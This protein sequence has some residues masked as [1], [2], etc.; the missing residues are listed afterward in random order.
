MRKRITQTESHFTILLV[1]T[2]ILLTHANT[3]THRHQPT[4]ISGK[5]SPV[6]SPTYGRQLQASLTVHRMRLDIDDSDADRWLT[7]GNALFYARYLI[8][9]RNMLKVKNYVE[10]HFR[11]YFFDE[12]EYPA[13]NCSSMLNDFPS[14]VSRSD[15]K[16]TM[17]IENNMDVD[18]TAIAYSCL[19]WQING[20]PLVGLFKLNLQ[21]VSYTPTSDF[22]LFGIFLHEIF[23]I[24]GFN[25][26]YFDSYPIPP[27][28]MESQT[29]W[30]FRTQLSI[31]LIKNSSQIDILPTFAFDAVTN[32][33][34]DH[35]GCQS[36]QGVPLENGGSAHG[37][38]LS[39]WKKI[40]MANEL[41]N[42]ST[43]NRAI[44]SN[45]SLSYLRATGWYGIREGAHQDW[46]YG[47]NRG[48][49]FLQICPNEGSEFCTEND[50]HQ[51]THDYKS[52]GYCQKDKKFYPNC[53]VVSSTEKHCDVD[54]TY[55]KA[56]KDSY[57]TF[58]RSSACFNPSKNNL[59]IPKCLNAVCQGSTAIVVSAQDRSS[60]MCTVDGQEFEL[61]GDKFVCPPI[62]DFCTKMRDRCKNDCEYDGNGI[63]LAG[64]TCFCF[65]G[66]SDN[67]CKSSIA[68]IAI[69]A[70]LS[71]AIAIS[72]IF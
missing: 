18:Y 48:C 64:G 16:L 20:R 51:C 1:F 12:F 10:N 44:I 39:H 37:T 6:Y 11:V 7:T 53:I 31:M 30:L 2:S 27:G 42:P 35:F 9:K 25:K 15:L 70:Y 50:K 72:T 34:R 66:E 4:S 23:H 45:I 32:I 21:G 67:K 22:S 26:F 29:S 41:M 68:G 8:I 71:L 63:C 55:S 38:Q 40:F 17:L 14:G 65:F 62:A 47:K 61:A 54:F 69:V 33:A 24:L 52:I 58:G 59:G 49:G 19:A 56:I 36:M 3:H 57:E 13:H 46:Y 60:V 5:Q 43:D 28:T